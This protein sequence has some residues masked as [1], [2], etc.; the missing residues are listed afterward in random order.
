MLRSGFA[1]AARAVALAADTVSIAVMELVDNSLVLLVPGAMD[2]GLA[3]MLFWG[4]SPSPVIAFVV[5]CRST[6][7]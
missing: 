5:T 3:D 6:A 1:S 4:S 7:G 2:A